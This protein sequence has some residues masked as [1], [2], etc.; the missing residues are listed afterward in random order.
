M[1]TATTSS[2]AAS[3]QPAEGGVMAVRPPAPAGAG[4]DPEQLARLQQCL[5]RVL[6]AQCAIGGGVAGAAF[7]GGSRPSGLLAHHAAP[8]SESLVDGGPLLTP[9]LLERL[10][11]VAAAACA[12]FGSNRSSGII[13][14]IAIQRSRAMYGDEMRLRA[15]AT[16]LVADGRAEGACVMLTKERGPA[17]DEATLAA[18]AAATGAFETHL[19]RE[20]CL[21]QTQQKL[22]L[23]EAVELLDA[24]Q[25]GRDASAMGAII[26]QELKRRFGCTRVSVGMVEGDF[27]RVA[28]MSG[29]DRVDR[30]AA[31][32][33]PLE[34]VME[35]CAAQDA[36]V[37][38]PQAADIEP[39]LRRVTREHERF[40]ATMGPCAMLSLPLRVEGGIV[41][42]VVL[43]REPTDPLPLP[44]AALLRL[45]A[46][47]IGPALWTRRMADRGVMAV[48]RDGLRDAA[49]SL[50]GPGHTGLKLLG[51][52]VLGALILSAVV[53]VPGRVS[54]PAGVKAAAARTVSP[55]FSGFLAK[56][57]VR[58][59]DR[60]TAGQPVAEMDSTD[61]RLQLAQAQGELGSSRTQR[62]EA[63]GRG[64]LAKVAQ[65]DAESRRAEATIELLESHLAR[66]VIASPVDGV[67][68]RGDL[69]Q[70]IRARVEP[71]QPL[72][73]IITDR[74][75]TVAYVD[76][77]DIQR[78]SVGQKGRFVSKALPGEA[79]DVNVARITPVAEPHE[80]ANAYQV[81]LTLGEHG[82]AS[83]LGSLRPGMTGTVKLDDGWTTP[84]VSFAR[85]LVDEARLRLW[86]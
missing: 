52:T 66:A 72:F 26:A 28:A 86:W 53:P 50:V 5:Q 57:L 1:G 59:G 75:V 35:E 10:E 15:F 22:M 31:A 80:G 73:E 83:T 43:E 70:F 34:A 49:R 17:S 14:A 63:L 3:D 44:A 46:E 84:L 13:D 19:W 37:I 9:P 18:L 62:D 8:G 4:P 55:P 60:V 64:D 40:S 6:A 61:L 71:N 32:I 76:E 2:P 36:E 77:R 58:P 65:Y 54:A 29:V 51:I 12:A 27:M 42:V 56:V 39:A 20:Q 41:G 21:V 23:R 82:D 69:E 45:V 7:L 30:T 48:A 81:E 85:P 25:Q 78:V 74:N 11:R 47:T 38:F 79:L 16:V 67:V 33:G 68:G 24:A